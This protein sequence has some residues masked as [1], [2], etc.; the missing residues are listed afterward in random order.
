MIVT[1]ECANC[2]ADTKFDLGLAVKAIIDA[3]EYQT[4]FGGFLCTEC[5]EVDNEN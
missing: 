1:V 2:K 3:A 5:G 4:I